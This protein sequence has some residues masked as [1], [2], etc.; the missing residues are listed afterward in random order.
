MAIYKSL[1]PDDISRVP[2]N[3]NRQFTFNSSSAGS[4]KFSIETFQYSASALDT[5]SSASTDKKN[6]IK[7]YQLDHLFY[8]NY[9]LD[10]SNKLGDAD[11][12]A[13]PRILY[14]KVNV[15]SIPS[16]LYGNGVNPGTFVF[17]GSN[18]V[19]IIDDKKGNLFVEG[20]KFDEYITDERK[21]VFFVG[22][23]KGFKQY[24]INYDLYN[25][26]NPNPL[27]HYNRSNVYDDS[28]YNNVIEYKNISFKKENLC[29]S[30]VTKYGANPDFKGQTDIEDIN[31]TVSPNITQ[32][33]NPQGIK[34]STTTTSTSQ[35]PAFR[36]DYI[37]L[38]PYAK[39]RVTVNV[40]EVPVHTMNLFMYKTIQSSVGSTQYRL[41][42][43]QIKMNKSLE[44]KFISVL[45]E[46]RT[47][48]KTKLFGRSE[49]MTSVLFNGSDD[50]IGKIVKVKIQNS[51]QNT[52]TGQIIEKSNQ[53]VA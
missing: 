25:K 15:L 30:L 36:T 39:Y 46:N 43:N 20:T 18:D 28:Y 21:K 24:N 12:L 7:Y 27:T 38:T 50:L 45:V 52:L 42:N 10:I 11:Y 44:N 37:T 33:P 29:P 16:N 9:R 51:N 5:F 23:V 19:T 49:Y 53:K 3:A 47:D 1:G 32:T 48:D 17:T 31:W 4:A 2:F 8:K 13:G 26:S 14:N 35:Y 22:P 6:T 41:F 34:F 40:F